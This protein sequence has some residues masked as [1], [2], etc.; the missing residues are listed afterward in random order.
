MLSLDLSL[1]PLGSSGWLHRPTPASHV[2]AHPGLDPAG[3]FHGVGWQAGQVLTSG[4][5]A[6][7][8]E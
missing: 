3:A 8:L 6:H 2:S 1:F 5:A 4:F 7:S